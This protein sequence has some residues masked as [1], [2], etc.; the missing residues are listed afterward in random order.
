MAADRHVGER[1]A[2]H[3]LL[4]PD[5]PGDVGE[6]R[7]AVVLEGRF[8][9]D[10]GAVAERCG[11]FVEAALALGVGDISKDTAGDVFLGEAADL[12]PLV[13]DELGGGVRLSQFG[14]VGFVDLPPEEPVALEAGGGWGASGSPQVL[15]V[16]KSSSFR[17]S[18]R[19]GSLWSFR[20]WHHGGFL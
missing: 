9:E 14:G 12:V 10:L 17:W 20:K 16:P 13:E 6:D 5:V 11:G 8:V 4:R 15:I 3:P 18:T 19:R 7:D 2:Q 1:A